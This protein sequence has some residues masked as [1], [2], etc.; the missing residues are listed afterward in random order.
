[1]KVPSVKHLYSEPKLVFS[2]KVYFTPPE[3]TGG[4]T[5][6]QTFETYIAEK[7]SRQMFLEADKRGVPLSRVNS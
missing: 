2:L 4:M 3:D 7:G 5:P 1:M 6:Y